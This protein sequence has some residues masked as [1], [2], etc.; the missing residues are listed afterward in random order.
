MCI[1]E[2]TRSFCGRISNIVPQNDHHV[3]STLRGL[4]L[5]LNLNI[6]GASDIKYSNKL[7]NYGDFITIFDLTGN[8]GH[9]KFKFKGLQDRR[10]SNSDKIA[11]IC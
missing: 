6:D 7:A 9:R 3:T 10:I 8:N 4:P 1:F 2:F 5:P 11:I